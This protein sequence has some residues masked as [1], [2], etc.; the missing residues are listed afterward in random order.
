MPELPEVQTVVDGLQI[1]KDRFIEDV[2]V[3]NDNTVKNP[4]TKSEF[5]N[6][7][8]G[9][10]VLDVFRRGKYIVFQL[11]G[12]YKLITHLRMT[13]RLVAKEDVISKYTRV[14]FVFNDG[15]KLNFNDVRKFGTMSLLHQDEMF[16]EKGYFN[17]GPE[18]LSQDFNKEY[19]LSKLASSR[20]I[21]TIIL[22][23][24]KIAGLG[25]IYADEC[26][27]L[28]GINPQRQGKSLTKDEASLLVDKIKL[29]LENAIEYGGTTFRDY[30]NSKGESG[31]FQ[32]CLFVY[33]RKGQL[34]L[35]CHNELLHEKIGGRTSVF[36]PNC[37][38]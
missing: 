12:E 5:E 11:D 34:C 18:P 37:Q 6:I 35:S 9:K 19:L 27:F 4:N 23:Q 33:G 3:Y 32:E 25:N 28:A 30:R 10:K 21:K 31:K 38:R 36:C 15:L 17:L 24:T 2:E 29:V 7:L 13:G 22:D 1:L 8:K 16:K 20:A 14:R 26:L